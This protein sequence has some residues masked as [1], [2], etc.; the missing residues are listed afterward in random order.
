MGEGDGSLQHGGGGDRAIQ[1]QGEADWKP[2]LAL[3]FTGEFGAYVWLVVRN[4]G[5]SFV[6][7]QIYRFWGRTR[8]RRFLWSHTRIGGEYLVYTGRGIELFLGFL[9][10]MLLFVAI[11]LLVGWWVPALPEKPQWRDILPVYLAMT[12]VLGTLYPL[13]FYRGWRYRLSRTRWGVLGCRW[14]AQGLALA[15]LTLGAVLAEFA[16]AG[17]LLPVT[18]PWLWRRFWSQVEIGGR[19]VSCRPVARRPLFVAVLMGQGLVLM[20]GL[21]GALLYNIDAVPLIPSRDVFLAGVWQEYLIGFWMGS[22][23]SSLVA[24]VIWRTRFLRQAVGAL[25]WEGVRVRLD[26]TIPRYGLYQ[27]GNLAL[28]IFTFGAGLALLPYRRFAFFCRHLEFRGA[29]DPTRL[30]AAGPEP[31]L[32]GEGLWEVFNLGAV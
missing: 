10:A 22:F 3:H 24:Y 9:L 23:P 20:S 29:P 7:F 8:L 16:S 25:S 1:A 19:A 11:A 21:A 2:P 13:A 15:V 30:K 14:R 12:A 4:A 27:L 31:G 26:L 17:L 32:T 6:T 5:L 28:V 18:R